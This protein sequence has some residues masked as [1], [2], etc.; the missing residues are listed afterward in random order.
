METNKNIKYDNWQKEMNN[1]DI[2]ICSCL[3]PEHQI[4]FRYDTEFNYVYMEV[5]LNPSAGF[6]KRIKLGLQYIFGKFNNN[7][8]FDDIIISNSNKH[9][10]QKVLNN[11]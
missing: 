6:F 4:V 8:F 7:Y 5:L 2:L 9:Q 1:P 3:T 10:F 11:F